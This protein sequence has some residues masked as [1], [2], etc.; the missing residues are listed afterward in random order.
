[1]GRAYVETDDTLGQISNAFT[2]YANYMGKQA[3]N[4]YQNEKYQA[5]AR[6]SAAEA[7][8]QE[9]E[10]QSRLSLYQQMGLEMTPDQIDTANRQKSTLSDVFYEPYRET[11]SGA[12]LNQ[13]TGVIDDQTL[14]A[15]FGRD[16]IDSEILE[17][18][19]SAGSSDA[20]AA[21]TRQD[22]ER[23]AEFGNSGDWQVI[24][25]IVDGKNVK[26][27]VNKLTGEVADFAYED[28]SVVESKATS[29]MR[30]VTHPDG[31]TEVIMGGSGGDLGRRPEGELE[32]KILNAEDQLDE[33][34]EIR[35]GV[36]RDLFEIPQQ[37]KA[38]M[39]AGL[40][41]MGR[42]PTPDE[43]DYIRRRENLFTP[44]KQMFNAYRHMIT[45]A[46]AAE[47]ELKRLESAYINDKLSYT[48]FN[49]RMG[50]LESKFKRDI[51][52]YKKQ[53]A[54]GVARIQDPNAGSLGGEF[55]GE[56]PVDQE[57]M[58]KQSPDGSQTAVSTDGGATW[59]TM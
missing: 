22:T 55:G 39:V 57:P 44:V 23:T 31:T 52:R 40:E 53:H 32:T 21:K 15:Q 9:F 26:A 25:T 45:G 50:A 51:A 14:A 24:D 2:G 34:I 43:V 28:G 30:V 17:N 3:Q 29:D 36:S 59:Q 10:N 41:K 4:Q 47:T 33:I 20:S 13:G 5:D 18:E 7:A 19:A 48:E 16:K 56:A 46:A 12:L 49:S 54:G 1:M 42:E 6:K 11:S 35:Q 8:G 38:M 37:Y 27:R 58:Y